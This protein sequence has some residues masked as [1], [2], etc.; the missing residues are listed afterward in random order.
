MLFR[1]VAEETKEYRKIM[2]SLEVSSEAAGYTAEQTGE[3]YRRLYGVLADEQS[4]ATTLAN[5]QALE[6]NQEDLLALIDNVIGGWAKYGDS[7][8]IDSLAE[9]V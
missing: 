7:I 9:A 4:A 1:S 8:P 3:A 2:G 5:L 6:L